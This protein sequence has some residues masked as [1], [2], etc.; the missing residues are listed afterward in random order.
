MKLSVSLSSDDVALLDDY[1]RAAGLKG[2][3]AVIQR[4]LALLRQEGLG[5][6]YAVAWE[7]WDNSGD[8]SA[9]DVTA[10]DGQAHA[11]R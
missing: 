9:W 11:S 4:A 1:A 7:E 10:G 3:S 6:D 5:E 8:R 2:R